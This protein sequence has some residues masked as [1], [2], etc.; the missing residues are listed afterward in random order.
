MNIYR[1]HTTEP[2][3]KSTYPREGGTIGSMIPIITIVSIVLRTD[4]ELVTRDH[5][6]LHHYLK[7]S[8]GG[9][10]IHLEP[11]LSVYVTIVIP[12]MN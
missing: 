5:S 4:K 1:K 10:V 12:N 9:S 6:C 7:Q 11:I 3:G 2:Y 8:P